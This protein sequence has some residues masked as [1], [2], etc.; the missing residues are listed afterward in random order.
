MKYLGLAAPRAG[1]VY[2]PWRRVP[3]G[4]SHLVVGIRRPDA[5]AADLHVPLATLPLSER[6]ERLADA[7]LWWLPIMGRLTPGATPA[8]VQGNLDGVLRAAAQSALASFLDGLTEEERGRARNR[9]RSAEP[10]LF[11]DSGRQRLY[12]ASLRKPPVVGSGT[13]PRRRR[14]AR[15]AHRVRQRGH[16][17]VAGGVTPAGSGDPHVGWGYAR[18]ADSPVW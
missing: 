6:D 2:V 1:S 13:G 7:T 11:V 15:A 4:V 17:A 18:A 16:L 3:T 5:A 8:Q 14:H 12:D 9:N 10:R